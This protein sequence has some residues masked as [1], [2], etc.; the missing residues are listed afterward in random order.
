MRLSVPYGGGSLNV[1]LPGADVQVIGAAELPAADEDDAIGRALGSP[2]G[3]RPLSEF[4]SGAGD[5]VVIVNDAKRPTPTARLL[6]RIEAEL[7]AVPNLTYLVATGTHRPPTSSEIERILGGAARSRAARVAVHDARDSSAMCYLGRTPLGTEVRV[8]RTV[9][10]A[11]RV[12][13]IGSVE[14]HYFAGFTGGRKAIVPGVA[15]YET[16]RQNHSHATHPGSQLMALRGNPVHED[17]MEGLALMGD[18]EIFSVTTVLDASHRICWAFAG[19]IRSTFDDAVER[20]REIYCVTIEQKAD[21]VVCVTTSPSDSDLYQAHKAIESGKLALETG[22]ILIL[23]AA[24]REGL[25]SDA[26]VRQLAASHRPEDV[27]SDIG[28]EYHLGD[29][30]AVKLAELVMRASVWTVTDLPDET[31]RGIF[32]RPF[33]DLQTALD[34]AL[35]VKGPGARVLALMDAAVTVP[36]LR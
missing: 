11:S 24:C 10:D 27:A 30:K 35:A 6:E 33:H 21:I 7:A 3:A 31:V 19:D 12:V 32:F 23:V 34:S 18:R 17:M 1:D 2:V 26:F 16:V 28:A 4:L 5:A 36:S 14:P 25:G 9:A 15:A 8:N 29:H 20:A 13:A 22:G